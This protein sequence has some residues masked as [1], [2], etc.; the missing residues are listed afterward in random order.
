MRHPWM[1]AA[2]RIDTT[3]DFNA[4]PGT[5]PGQAD[6]GDPRLRPPAVRLATSCGQ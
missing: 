6:D 4:L 3:P 2:P 1:L 5:V